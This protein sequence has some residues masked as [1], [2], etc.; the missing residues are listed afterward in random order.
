M[1]T[2]DAPP[3]VRRATA[4]RSTAVPG[5]QPYRATGRP[6]RLPAAALIGTS[7]PLPVRQAAT[8]PRVVP[9]GR[10]APAGPATARPSPTISKEP[11][12]A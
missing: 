1:R 12:R 5:R 10:G 7:L 2:P 8:L 4:R 3:T 11:R 9:S 6:G